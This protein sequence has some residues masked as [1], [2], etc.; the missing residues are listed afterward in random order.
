MAS[1]KRVAIARSSAP[2]PAPVEET[3]PAEH[4]RD[5]GKRQRYI[6]GSMVIATLALAA[7]YFKAITN[8]YALGVIIFLYLTLRF[9]L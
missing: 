2:K 8:Q 6:L 7:A 9:T 3:Q 5:I 4:L 1:K